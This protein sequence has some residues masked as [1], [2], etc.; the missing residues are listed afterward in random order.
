ME[1]QAAPDFP[2]PAQMALT[3]KPGERNATMVLIDAMKDFVA[4]LARGVG[5]F[6]SERN[7]FASDA[8][9]PGLART[10]R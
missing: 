1:T 8:V 10:R 5:L 3:R 6:F 4:G 9:A 2:S 7:T